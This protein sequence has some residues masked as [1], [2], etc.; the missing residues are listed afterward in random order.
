MGILR[1]I[2]THKYLHL[3]SRYAAIT[4]LMSK[5]L[6]SHAVGLPATK[7]PNREENLT[8]HVRIVYAYVKK[9]KKIN[10]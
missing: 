8:K 1:E 5:L 6:K 10:N 3:Q 7:K 4:S 9:A 2:L